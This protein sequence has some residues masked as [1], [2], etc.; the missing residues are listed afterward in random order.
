MLAANRLVAC[1]IYTHFL[2]FRCV[3]VKTAKGINSEV[4]VLRSR[5]GSADDQPVY[6]NS[7]TGNYGVNIDLYD[8][9]LQ[10]FQNE[11]NNVTQCTQCYVATRVTKKVGL[12]Y[13]CAL[14]C[15]ALGCN[16]ERV[17]P[18]YMMTDERRRGPKRAA[19]DKQFAL[20]VQ[21]SGVGMHGASQFLASLDIAPVA[22]SHCQK[23]AKLADTEMS[24]VNQKDTDHIRTQTTLNNA[25]LGL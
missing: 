18:Q 7:G 24:T 3:N 11:H 13:K 17:Y 20:A 16:Y 4:C 23:L 1:V 14:K 2:L 15:Q 10:D 6:I 19:V 21:D 8:E 5:E 9:A 25:L 22:P 12:S